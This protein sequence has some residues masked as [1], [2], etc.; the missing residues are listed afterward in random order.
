MNSIGVV[1]MFFF[2][3]TLSARVFPKLANFQRKRAPD[4][5]FSMQTL[6]TICTLIWPEKEQE[7]LNFDYFANMVIFRGQ[8]MSMTFMTI[9]LLQSLHE[10]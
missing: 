9:L 3:N 6:K 1:E 10:V 2:L 8:N 5:S 4:R 7:G